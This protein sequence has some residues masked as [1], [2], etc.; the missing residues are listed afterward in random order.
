[1]TSIN[2]QL[3][4]LKSGKRIKVI[5]T[6]T[7]MKQVLPEGRLLA[8]DPIEDH[9]PI[10]S[11]DIVAVDLFGQTC[12]RLVRAVSADSYQLISGFNRV[13]GWFTRRTLVGIVKMEES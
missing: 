7:A 13:E 2:E 12:L 1:M 3:N 6:D 8:I 9:S 4:D 5:N 10:I 11:G